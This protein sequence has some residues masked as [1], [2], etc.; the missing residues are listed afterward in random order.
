MVSVKMAPVPPVSVV[1]SMPMGRAEEMAWPVREKSVS[2]KDRAGKGD[3]VD[4]RR[5]PI[6]RVVRRHA[7]READRLD[8]AP[9]D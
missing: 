3:G 4:G 9:G 1:E 2:K 7:H 8:I 5:S 6:G